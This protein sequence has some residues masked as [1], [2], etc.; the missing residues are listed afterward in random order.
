MPRLRLFNTPPDAS[1]VGVEGLTIAI[2]RQAARDLTHTD[3]TIRQ[4]AEAFVR[5]T[6]AVD[7]WTVVLDV[8]AR[9]FQQWARRALQRGE[10]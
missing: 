3:P 7:A 6:D 1:L 4:D 10:P 2:L 8:D 9:L 5:D